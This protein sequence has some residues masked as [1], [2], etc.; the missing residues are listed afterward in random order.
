MSLAKNFTL[1][2]QN[3][4][5]RSDFGRKSKSPFWRQNDQFWQMSKMII[6]V[7]L[8]KF[9]QNDHKDPTRSWIWSKWPKMAKIDH[10]DQLVK[11]DHFWP[12]WPNWPNPAKMTIRIRSDPGPGQ[13]GQKW[14]FLRP[15]IPRQNDQFLT[16]LA[17]KSPFCPPSPRPPPKIAH[18]WPKNGQK[19]PLKLHVVL[20][21]GRSQ[22]EL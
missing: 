20:A 3:L 6:L 4:T 12:F 15:A 11:N 13:N 16:I 21:L 17:P 2:G 10:F 14:P 8:T 22:G 7:I 9:D 1:P 5:F 18:F 19:W